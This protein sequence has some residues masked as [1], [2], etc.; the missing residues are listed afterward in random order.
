MLNFTLKN[1]DFMLRELHREDSEMYVKFFNNLNNESLRCRF[2]HLLAKLTMTEAAVRTDH[3]LQN[4]SA[5]AIFDAQQE[6]I[7]GIGRCYLDPDNNASE[8]A[9]VV[10]EDMRGM[11]LGR[12]LLQHLIQ[13]AKESGS[14]LIH[15]YVATRNAP[16]MTLLQSC[17]FV[18][19]AS[20]PSNT[21]E[22]IQLTLTLSFDVLKMN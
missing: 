13:T 21:E 11:G 20:T 17:G 8:V 10:S 15:A 16:V 18:K 14:T 12:Y 5:L 9:L 4:E 1:Q 7:L 6:Q 2:G 22:D 3:T 19:Q